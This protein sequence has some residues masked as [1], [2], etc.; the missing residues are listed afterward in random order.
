MPFICCV[1]R[2]A[3]LN[4]LKNF[5]GYSDLF[6]TVIKRCNSG[7]N[8]NSDYTPDYLNP[9]DTNI[10]IGTQNEVRSLGVFRNSEVDD[11]DLLVRNFTAPALARALRNRESALQK[12]AV[13]ANN[14]KYEELST[15]LVPF[16]KSNVD[17]RRK[18]QH[19]LDLSA[20]FSRSQLVIIQRYLHRLPRQVFDRSEKRASVVIPL[21]N[22]NGVASVL[23]E[24]RSSMVRTY[25]KQVCFPGGMLD[26]GIDNTIIQTSLRETEEELGIPHEKVEV[27]GI[28]RCN[29]SEVQGYT[30]IAV[31]PVV[32]YIGELSDMTLTPN[33]DEVEKY[34]TVPLE[35]IIDRDLWQPCSNYTTQRE[36]TGGPHR[37]FGLTAYLLDNFVEN[38]VKKCSSKFPH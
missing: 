10:L 5:K 18:R 24:Q 29:W 20:G 4:N 13:L 35:R 19:T 21:C 33:K 3:H 11:I 17:K 14:G 26:E 7:S 28:L 9:Q 30:G 23:F 38:V 37:V 1:R 15:M 32:G 27:L 2:A 36:F 8:S 25:K 6:C 31:T 22:V 34:F 12:A 16:L